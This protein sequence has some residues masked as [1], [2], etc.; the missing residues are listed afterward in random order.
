MQ[1]YVQASQLL[2]SRSFS[3]GKVKRAERKLR[4]EEE[5]AVYRASRMQIP[6]SPE[7]KNMSQTLFWA[8]LAC[9]RML[10]H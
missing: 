2:M 8:F 10:L 4:F 6:A 9:F 3:L 7:A 1:G 5:L